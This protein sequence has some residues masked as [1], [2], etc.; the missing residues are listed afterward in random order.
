MISLQFGYGR[1]NEAKSVIA[2][3][4]Q[5]NV[6]CGQDGPQKEA[7]NFQIVS[8][9]DGTVAASSPRDFGILPGSSVITIVTKLPFRV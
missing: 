5:T 9:A 2:F 8:P 3:A 6:L 4:D 1:A 7:L